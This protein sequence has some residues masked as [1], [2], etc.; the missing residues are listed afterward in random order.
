MRLARRALP[1]LWPLLLTAGIC[2]PLLAPG[3]V[4]SY[5]LVFVPD[6]TLRADLFGVGTALPRAVP[7][8]VVVAIL[9]ELVGGMVLNKLVLLAIPA[10]AGYGMIRL[11]RDLR[12]GRFAGCAAATLFVWNPYVAER[13][14]LGHWPLLIG[15]AALPWLTSSV[16]RTRR[17][18]AGTWPGLVLASAGCA[19]TASGGLV[20]L[21]LAAAGLLWP[22]RAPRR[23]ALLGACLLVNLPWLVAGLAHRGTAV[24]DRAGV[25][26]FAARDEGYG[27]VLPTLLTLGGVWNADV[28]PSGRDAPTAIAGA[29]LLLAL[30]V[31]GVALWWRRDRS[32][33]GP[34]VVTGL[35]ALAIAAVGAVVPA[36]LGWIV[37]SVPGGGLLRDGQRYLGPLALLEATGF[38]LAA[39][40]LV[41]RA[42]ASFAG[43][44]AADV[45]PSVPGA[46]IGSVGV[47]G[48][49]VAVLLLPVAVLP[50]LAAGAGLVPSH[51]PDDW[52]QLRDVLAAD[53]RPGDVMPWPFESYRAPSWNDGRPVLDPMPRYLTRASV[54]PDD[55]VV[56]GRRISGEDPRAAEISAALRSGT[57]ADVLRRQGIG[58]IVVDLEAARAAGDPTQAVPG[59]TKVYAGPTVAAYVTAARPDARST[60]AARVPVFAAFVL[61]GL[62]VLAAS[63]MAFIRR[64]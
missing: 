14:V 51:Y 1:V 11:L 43:A 59:L 12:A 58:W 25:A 23:F 52:A 21:L 29:F 46:R 6:L 39:A 35:I 30:S 33:A 37:E 36:L 49:A 8:D 47:A 60:P 42:R 55:L 45:P 50:G 56:G 20:G 16:V 18:D 22:G 13:L 54:V 34:A 57:A 9:D 32:T 2:A 7:S 48:L 31:I 53:D 19:L 27:G 4:L 40:W 15:Y 41:A 10:L 38:G 24:I 62:T 44:R 63:V 64:K 17:G 28:V 61:A 3:Y 26:A 5:D